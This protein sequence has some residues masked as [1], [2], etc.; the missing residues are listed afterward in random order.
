MRRRRSRRREVLLR[1]PR[2]AAR[3]CG[4]ARGSAGVCDALTILMDDLRYSC[5]RTGDNQT[6]QGLQHRHAHE[7]S[8]RAGRPH[9]QHTIEGGRERET[10]SGER[11]R[12]G[13]RE[14]G[15]ERRQAS[16]AGSDGESA[17]AGKRGVPSD[18]I[19]DQASSINP[20][21]CPWHRAARPRGPRGSL[22]HRRGRA[23]RGRDERAYFM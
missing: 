4:A 11:P 18:V 10:E 19:N 13:E 12:E 21:T 17:M 8:A 7:C 5:T 14:G 23:R 15:R 16:R 22:W 2:G 1:G 9:M 3:T 6:E 20:T